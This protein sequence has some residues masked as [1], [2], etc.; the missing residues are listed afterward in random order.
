VAGAV[1]SLLEA[2]V[3][4]A[5]QQYLFNA[6]NVDVFFY[7]F[8]GTEMSV[9]GQ[10]AL[11]LADAVQLRQFIAHATETKFQM[12]EN[13][14]SCGQMSTGSFYKIARCAHMVD[15]H[16]RQHAVHYTS[17]LLTRPDL[18]L[19]GQLPTRVPS[20]PSWMSMLNSETYFL[21]YNVGVRLSMSLPGALCCDHIRR[22]PRGCFVD[23]LAKPD[24]AFIK[25]QHFMQHMHFSTLAHVPAKIVRSSQQVAEIAHRSCHALHG[26]YRDHVDLAPDPPSVTADAFVQALLH[27]THQGVAATRIAEADAVHRNFR[28]V[29]NGRC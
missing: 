18:R 21:E 7:L 22:T 28:E 14:F 1:R 5:F 6:T 25:E 8:V 19:L 9:K 10:R 26:K 23:G 15:K 16:A 3:R 29:G 4:G 17:L 2:D 12:V 24:V 11:K 20:I 13:N 27:S